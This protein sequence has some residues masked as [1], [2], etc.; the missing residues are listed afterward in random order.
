[1]A[2]RATSNVYEMRVADGFLGFSLAYPEDELHLL[3]LL[4]GSQLAAGWIAPEVVPWLEIGGDTPR[5]GDMAGWSAGEP[6][7]SERARLELAA[8]LESRAEALP[9][10]SSVGKY[11][12][13]NVTCLLPA[14]VESIGRIEHYELDPTTV[15]DASIFKLAEWPT[16]KVLVAHSF[17]DTVRA[18]ELTGFEFKKIWPHTD[19]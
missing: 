16:G 14:L 13:I 3:Q 5:I 2:V 9:I 17:V 8:H 6:V 11:F 12:L 4:N 19:V 10:K 7:L 18:A 1:M 15:A